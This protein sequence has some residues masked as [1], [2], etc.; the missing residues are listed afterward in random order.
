MRTPGWERRLGAT[1]ER[2][3]K[4]AFA[5][6][7]YDCAT[8]VR[9]TALALGAADPFA[10]MIWASKLDSIMELRR[11]GVRSVREFF[12]AGLDAV[13]VALAQRGD[14]G[15][16]RDV[17]P[18]MCPAI[19]TGPEAVSRDEHGWIVLPRELL[20]ECYR[21]RCVAPSDMPL[22]AAA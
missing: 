15:F 6:G 11:A 4:A 16:T 20:V 19:V 14:V 3:R 2:H 5:W 9:D 7:A 12:A 13:P 22:L 17:A 18:L 21:F 10:G 8:L 1:L